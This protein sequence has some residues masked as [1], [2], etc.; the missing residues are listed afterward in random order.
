MVAPGH[1]PWRA[2]RYVVSILHEKNDSVA[3]GVARPASNA[4]LIR[5]LRAGPSWLGWI[6]DVSGQALASLPFD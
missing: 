6:D 2:R 4:L 5:R 1:R 3:T